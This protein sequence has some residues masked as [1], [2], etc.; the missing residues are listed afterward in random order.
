LARTGDESHPAY[1]A[2]WA[3][4]MLLFF[5]V[6]LTAQAR[7]ASTEIH[8]LTQADG[9]SFR[10]H[11]WGDEFYIG[12]E[13]EDGYSIIFDSTVNCW[14]YAASNPEG[15]LTASPN[16]VGWSSPPSGTQR[17]L[18]PTGNAL[19]AIQQKRPLRSPPRGE[20]TI[21]RQPMMAKTGTNFIL[22]LPVDF[23]D[24]THIIGKQEFEDIFFKRNNSSLTDYYL[25]NSYGKLALS[26][27]PSGIQDWWTAPNT[28]DYYGTDD[29]NDPSNIDV[30]LPE[31]VLATVTA[32]DRR[33]AG[34]DFAPYDQDR[35]CYVDTV[36]FIFQ[37]RPQSSTKV[38]NDIFPRQSELNPPYTTK[39]ACASGGFI[40][41][42]QYTVQTEL[43]ADGKVATI[44][45]FAH[46]YGHALGLPDL[47]DTSYVSTGIGIWSVMANGES[48]R[49]LREGDSPS[50]FDAWSKFFLG[51]VTPIKVT[52]P[53]TN[54][55]IPAVEEAATVYQLLAGTWNSGEYFL[56]ENRQYKGFDWGLAGT[57]L[58][59]WHIDGNTIQ[60]RYEANTVNNYPCNNGTS[61][62]VQR[63]GV[64]LQQ[65][66]GKWHLEQN[67]ASGNYGDG[68]DPFPGNT[69]NSSFTDS[70]LPNSKLYN[71]MN[72]NV[73]VT[74]IAVSDEGLKASLEVTTMDA[75]APPPSEEPSITGP[76]TAGPAGSGGG[77]GGG[78]FIATAAFG[79]YFDPYVVIL[80]TFRDRFLLKTSLGQDFVEWYYRISP[81]LADIIGDRELLKKIVRLLLLPAVGLSWLCITVGPVFTLF[82]VLLTLFM[83]W[84]AVRR[85]LKKAGL[86]RYPL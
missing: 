23:N 52:T 32:L 45:T 63:Y 56:V 9:S 74:A 85:R 50:H 21:L 75:A 60:N 53:L 49:R 64:A 14:A 84:M 16:I 30:K 15:G 48:N 55:T 6:P 72:S 2:F 51:W 83:I 19:L 65:A 78:C 26:S 76:V 20:A 29:T 54:V 42:K 46:E 11:Q 79:S 59:I 24:K 73:K 22:V 41:V 35:D 33:A 57:G 44:G 13:T 7:P 68:G 39:T 25:E 27:G 17:H 77:G 71:G 61:C 37:G 58:L 43:E 38:L 40:K 36:A 82:L 66:D 70:S 1:P 18:R 3:V 34:F 4:L 67:K 69:G 80:R 62:S 8:T 81:P 47:Y 86:S 10:A 12:W 5:L 28:H 31:A